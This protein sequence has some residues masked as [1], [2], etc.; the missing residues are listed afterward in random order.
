MLLKKLLV[1]LLMF[2]IIVVAHFILFL[3]KAFRT[4]TP[5]KQDMGSLA[6]LFTALAYILT[7]IFTG[8]E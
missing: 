8:F 6:I 4:N 7:I 2:A 1:F 3:I 5:I